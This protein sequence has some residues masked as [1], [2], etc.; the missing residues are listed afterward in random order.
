MTCKHVVEQI[1]LRE[2]PDTWLERFRL[3][4]HLSL[5]QAC[6]YYFKASRALQHAVRDMTNSSLNAID[7]RKLNYDLLEKYGRPT[8]RNAE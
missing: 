7:L 1:D 3:T 2:R 6:S 5:C 4:L 8:K